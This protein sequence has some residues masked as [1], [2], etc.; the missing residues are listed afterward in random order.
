MPQNPVNVLKD[1]QGGKFAPIYFLDG[2][3]P[4]YVDLI[5]SFIEK[6]AIAEHEKSFNQ[7]VLYGKDS[8]MGLILNNARKFPMM[9]ERQVVI[10]KEFQSL[11]DLG[12]EDSVKLLQGYLQNPLPST[13]LVLAH[14]HKKLDGRSALYRDLDKKAV[15]VRSD[16]VQDYKLPAWIDA[17]FKDMGHSIE[18]KACQLLADSIGN[19]LEVL[20]NEVGKMLIN[21]QGATQ[22]TVDHISKYIGINKDYN[23]FELLKAIGFRDVG[24]ANKIIHYFSQNPKAHPVIP[25]FSLIYNYF[26]RIA[27]IHQS[28]VYSDSQVA[29]VIGVPPF[30]AKEYVIAARNYK[31]GKVIEVFRYIK[32]ADLR[33]KGVDSGSLSESENLRELVYKILH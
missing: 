27:L 26:T 14:K 20:T 21:F 3:E 19:N 5:T 10:V 28:K 8:N 7:I 4:F 6:N 30:V 32:E 15:Y 33:F 9:A 13:I 24:K 1:L 2:E 18:P 25:L 23:N 22:V 29:S 12:K 31:L 17:Y 11:P 16:K